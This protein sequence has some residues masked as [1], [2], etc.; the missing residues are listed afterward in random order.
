MMKL[1]RRC[2]VLPEGRTNE[3][4]ARLIGRE[5]TS[6]QSSVIG[7][8]VAGSGNPKSEVRPAATA[9]QRGESKSEIRSTITGKERRGAECGELINDERSHAGPTASDRPRGLIRALAGAIC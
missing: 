7:R 3:E 1:F 6:G 4:E 2:E 9:R 8:Q 5:L